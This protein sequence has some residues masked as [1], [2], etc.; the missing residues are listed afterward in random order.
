MNLLVR[1]TYNTEVFAK[2]L[3]LAVSE[4]YTLYPFIKKEFYSNDKYHSPLKE[5][6][7]DDDIVQ[8]QMNSRKKVQEVTSKKLSKTLLSIMPDGRTRAKH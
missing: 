6:V 4:R 3:S 2:A 7:I 1:T 5:K 8:K